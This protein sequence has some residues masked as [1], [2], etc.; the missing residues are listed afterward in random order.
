MSRSP[1]FRYEITTYRGNGDEIETRTANAEERK[2]VDFKQF[3]HMLDTVQGVYGY[4]SAS[5]E[6]IQRPIDGSG[7]GDVA[8]NIIR[9]LQLS[10][11]VLLGVVEFAELTGDAHLY[12]TSALA[13]RI[14][15]IRKAHGETPASP[16]FI[17]TCRN[18]GGYMWPA[19][20]SWIWID[21]I[22]GT[23]KQ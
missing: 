7:M 11:G 19:A 21:R 16:R 18:G 15:V 6:W 13:A 2:A 10:P 9:A 1:D 22:P 20:R 4:R 12:D 23:S 14:M 3:D 5:G 17:V 8:L